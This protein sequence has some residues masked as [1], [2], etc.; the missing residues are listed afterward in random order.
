MSAD[1]TPRASAAA[2]SVFA[3]AAAYF[4]LVFAAGCA[5]GII[6]VMILAPGL[7]RLGAV[8]AELPV[9]LAISWLVCGWV[10]RVYKVPA[11]WD[12]RFAIGTIAFVLLMLAEIGI[13]K[14]VFGR[15]LGEHFAAYR[16]LDGA[17]GLAAQMACG[18]FPVARLFAGMAD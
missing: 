11:R 4:A 16:N 13:A 10:L 15:S 3:A 17:L 18:A 12:V 2:R 9:M 7:G 1:A 6:R 14:F 5:A 8:I